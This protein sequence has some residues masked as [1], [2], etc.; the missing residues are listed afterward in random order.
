MNIDDGLQLNARDSIQILEVPKSDLHK[1]IPASSL[2]NLV[3]YYLNLV[4]AC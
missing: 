1:K 2:L 4:L 3:F